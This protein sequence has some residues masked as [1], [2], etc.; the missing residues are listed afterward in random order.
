MRK[1]R[2][3]SQNCQTIPNQIYVTAYL[4]GKRRCRTRT[5]LIYSGLFKWQQN[6]IS[7]V[8]C[9]YYLFV[10]HFKMSTWLESEFSAGETLKK[11]G[12]QSQGVCHSFVSSPRKKASIVVSS[13]FMIQSQSLSQKSSDIEKGFSQL[14]LFVP[15]LLLPKQ[16]TSSLTKRR[17][18]TKQSHTNYAKHAMHVTISATRATCLKSW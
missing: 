10:F 5:A 15:S 4:L 6:Y 14:Q 17:Q 11:W 2:F 9:S 12:V 3:N 8:Y 18:K 13:N 1:E 16:R 7:Q